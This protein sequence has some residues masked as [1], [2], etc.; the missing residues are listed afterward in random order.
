MRVNLHT[1]LGWHLTAT[2][3]L[4]E[5]VPELEGAERLR[6]NL[7]IDTNLWAYACAEKERRVRQQKELRAELATRASV[8]RDLVCNTADLVERLGDERTTDWCS[9]CLQKTEHRQVETGFALATFLCDS[10]GAATSPCVAPRCGHMATRE[11]GSIRIPRFC[12]EHRHDVTDFEAGDLRISDL[13]EFEELR[14]F[15]KRNLA[16][17]TKVAGTAVVAAGAMTGVGLAAAPL[18]G[19]IVGSTVGGYSGAAATSYGLA[20]LGGGPAAGI[21]FGM[22]GGTA[23]VAAVGGSLGGAMGAS[24]TQAYVGEDDSFRIEKLKDGVGPVVIV[25]SGFLTQGKSGWGDWERIVTERYPESPIYRVHWG[26]R[27]LKDLGAVLGRGAG[28]A[29][30]SVAAKTLAK[31]ASKTAATRA[32]PIG[33]GMIFLDLAKNPWWRARDRANK[34]GAILADLIARTD[35]DEVILTGHSLGARAMICAAEALGTKPSAPRILDVHL[36]GAAANSQR[37]WS[38][39]ARAVTG[40]AWNYHS[41]SDRVLRFFYSLGEAGQKAAGHEGIASKYAEIVNVDVTKD[42][43]EHSAYAKRLS[44]R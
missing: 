25:A 5:A 38:D 8:H 7:V 20:L 41:K 42:V 9:S 15:T 23:V 31:K 36:L 22:A 32:N 27:E 37:D 2:G 17:T 34:T 18:V 1:P 33:A 6:R 19:G 4:D 44:L 24:L 3:S 14:K 10:C 30:L 39:L 26:S 21:G 35:L 28:T 13:T 11:F 16:A 29:S 43:E 12:A 40:K